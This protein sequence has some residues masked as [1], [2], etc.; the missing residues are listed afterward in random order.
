MKLR[1]PPPLFQ[2]LATTLCNCAPLIATG[3]P[4]RIRSHTLRLIVL[5]SMQLFVLSI[6]SFLFLHWLSQR[7]DADYLGAT[8][9]LCLIVTTTTV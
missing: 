7:L 3:V 8:L 1:P 9:A 2:V 5:C 4:P 6:C